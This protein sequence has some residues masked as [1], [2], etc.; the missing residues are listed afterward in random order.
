MASVRFENVTKLYGSKMAINDLSLECKSGE[1]FTIVGPAGAGK[2][3]I[4]KMAAGIETITAG[5]IYFNETIVNEFSPGERN[6]SMAFETYN[7]YPHFSVYE[8]IA[9]PCRAAARKEKISSQEEHRRV[10]EIADLLGIDK[11][12][13]RRPVEL[14]GGEKQRVSLARALIRECECFLLDEPIAHLD[15]RLKFSTQT[16]LKR[17]SM[18]LG[19]TI[20][21]VTHDYRGALGMSDRIAVLRKGEIEQIGTPQEIFNTPA[22]DFVANFIGD[23][24]CNLI[25][26]EIFKRDGQ[27]LFRSG[28]DFTFRLE[29]KS[30][31]SA[32]KVMG[33]DI[34]GK[35]RLGIRANYVMASKH[36]IP[37]NTF[38]LTVYAIVRRP[39]S[40]ILTFELEGG[41]FRAALKGTQHYEMSQKVWIE[42]DQKHIFFFSKTLEISK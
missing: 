27:V 1:F 5:N 37:N 16:A 25:D 32:V 39:H 30:V 33:E 21:Y 18:N 2:S 40:T 42:I 17:L 35:A 12:L 23:P 22:T 36:E 38:P 31:E 3:T 26:G 14:S 10:V 9:F 7:L 19:A 29:E 4:L 20:I 6:V 8:N 15:A 13:D 28:N 41:F 11:L 34:E 24:P